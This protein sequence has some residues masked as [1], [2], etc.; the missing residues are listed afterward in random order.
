MVADETDAVILVGYRCVLTGVDTES[1]LGF[2]YL[3][4]D[5]NTQITTEELEQKIIITIWVA[6]HN[7]F[8]P[9][10]I[11]LIV[12]NKWAERCPQSTSLIEN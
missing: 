3:T 12:S 6:N 1:G 10:N 11:Q 2:G 7:F 4:V 9:R 8:R 5:A